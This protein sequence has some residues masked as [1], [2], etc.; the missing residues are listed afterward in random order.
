[1]ICGSHEPSMSWRSIASNC[2]TAVRWT[3]LTIVA[4]QL[5]IVSVPPDICTLRE[6]GNAGTKRGPDRQ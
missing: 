1:M 6:V 2:C 4:F 5:V 3:C